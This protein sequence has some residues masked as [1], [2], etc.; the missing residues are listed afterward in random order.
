M[1]AYESWFAPVPRSSGLS[2]ITGLVLVTDPRASVATTLVLQEMG[3]AVDL[4]SEPTYAL[5]WLRHTRYDVVVLGG[6]EVATATFAER[7]RRAAPDARIIMIASG[8]LAP[9]A[10]ERLQVEVLLP[11]VDVN[12]LVARLVPVQQ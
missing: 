10:M 7:I 2:T 8:D 9:E 6:A 12:M 11:P 1:S 4:G 3:Y 5:R